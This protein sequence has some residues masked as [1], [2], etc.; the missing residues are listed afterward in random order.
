MAKLSTLTKT[1]LGIAIA[2]VLVF[3]LAYA[4]N[5]IYPEPKIDEMCEGIAYR[6]EI[7]SCDDYNGGTIT[8][9]EL[10][11]PY[12][13]EGI[14]DCYCREID[15]K[16]TLKCEI[17]NPDYEECR[18]EYNDSREKHGRTSFVV[19]VMLGLAAILIGG[20]VI[21]VNAV[22]QGIMGGGVITLLYSAMRFWGSIEDYARLIILGVTLFILIWVGYKK[23]KE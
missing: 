9:G 8:K 14:N 15:A 23:F 20:F 2:L 13:E 22:S 7:D 21:K 1:I 17:T 12:P 6:T 11:I 10:R 19:L 3:F 16:G 18:K 5:T 4:M